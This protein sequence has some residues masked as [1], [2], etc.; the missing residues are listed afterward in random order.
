[1]VLG[2]LETGNGNYEAALNHL[3]DADKE[4]PYVWFCQAAAQE[5]AGNKEEAK[6]MYSKVGAYNEN[7]MGLAVVRKK[8]QDKAK[9]F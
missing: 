3:A 7:S 4:S 9:T 6:K 1:M 8:A 5:K 2:M